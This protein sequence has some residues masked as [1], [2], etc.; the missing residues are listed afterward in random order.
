MPNNEISGCGFYTTLASLRKR[1]R[2]KKYV[3]LGGSGIQ[4]FVK[5][6]F[7]LIIRTFSSAY[8]QYA[9]I[10]HICMLFL[11]TDILGVCSATFDEILKNLGKI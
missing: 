3:M 8:A 5:F 1:F 6:T 2:N 7:V 4:E 10:V 9:Q 11:C